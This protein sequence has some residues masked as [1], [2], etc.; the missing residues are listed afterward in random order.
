[1]LRYLVAA[2]FVALCLACGAGTAAT[3]DP[4]QDPAPATVFATAITP[5]S[6]DPPVAAG[7]TGLGRPMPL[8]QPFIVECHACLLA[9]RMPRR[10]GDASMSVAVV[11]LSFATL[12]ALAILPAMARDD[13]AARQQFHRP[14]ATRAFARAGAPGAERPGARAGAVT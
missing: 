10:A 3:V 9:R 12:I 2:W 1:M 14:G 8:V 5:A 4:L 6:F 7:P 11:W 13:G